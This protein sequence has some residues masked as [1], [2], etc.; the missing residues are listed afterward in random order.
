MEAIK[1]AFIIGA[2]SGSFCTALLIFGFLWR[3]RVLSAMSR[4]ML[5][6]KHKRR[7][8]KLN[9]TTIP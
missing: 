5:W 7:R 4:L 2:V 3:D 6:L 8:P 9:F 1:H